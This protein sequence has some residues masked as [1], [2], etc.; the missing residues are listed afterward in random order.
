M[1]HISSDEIN[2]LNALFG[3]M[4]KAAVEIKGNAPN[5]KGACEQIER[6]GQTAYRL[7]NEI[8]GRGSN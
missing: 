7:L 6:H 2:R 4:V 1:P 5:V 8:Q 3:D